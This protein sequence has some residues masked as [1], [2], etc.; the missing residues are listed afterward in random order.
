MPALALIIHFAKF[1]TQTNHHPS[2][3]LSDSALH[4]NQP[5][6]CSYHEKDLG[7]EPLTPKSRP[8]NRPQS[9]PQNSQSSRDKVDGIYTDNTCEKGDYA[10]DDSI[11]RQSADDE[12]EL[13]KFELL[14][15]YLDD[16][17][18]T[19]ERQQV[20]QWLRSDAELRQQYETQLKLRQAMKSLL[21]D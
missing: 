14:S 21:R 5:P 11:K 13:H 8:Q 7:Q 19:E 17:V 9:K 4:S 16:E 15:A 18:S 20:E 1:M 6:T 3:T 2:V 12:F 10:A